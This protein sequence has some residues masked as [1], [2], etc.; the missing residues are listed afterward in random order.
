MIGSKHSMLENI[1]QVM[2]LE[3]IIGKTF[4]DLFS[5]SAVVGRYFKNMLYIR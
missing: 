5:G 4:M 2:K 3:D 1:E